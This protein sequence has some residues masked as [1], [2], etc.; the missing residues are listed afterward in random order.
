MT[1]SEKQILE[2]KI[3]CQRNKVAVSYCYLEYSVSPMEINVPI[4][5]NQKLVQESILLRLYNAVKKSLIPSQAR[6]SRTRRSANNE[7]ECTSVH[8]RTV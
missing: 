1:S 4:M 3:V 2:Y 6:F 8:D 5:V 7:R